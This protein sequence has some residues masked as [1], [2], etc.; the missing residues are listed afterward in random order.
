MSGLPLPGYLTVVVTYLEMRAPPPV[1]PPPPNPEARIRRDVRPSVDGYRFLYDGVGESW[2]WSERRG[3]GA[4]DLALILSDPRLQWLVLSQG[5]RIAGFA[6][7]DRRPAPDI[8]LAYLGLLPG[9]CGCGLGSWLLAH[10]L[11]QAWRGRPRRVLV[12]TCTFDHPAA[13]GLYQRAGF[14]PIES[15]VRHTPDPRLTGL[16]PRDAAPHVPL[17]T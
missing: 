6:E 16:L 12:N 15:I 1:P 8:R 4:T 2:L 10:T 17:A 13:L 3:L 9:Y 7:L 11:D 5:R 14:T